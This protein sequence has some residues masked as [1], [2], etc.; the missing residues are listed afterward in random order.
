M[1]IPVNM[2]LVA[3]TGPVLVR[4]WQHRPSTG[5]VLAHSGMFMGYLKVDAPVTTEVKVEPG[6]KHTVPTTGGIREDTENSTTRY[7]VVPDMS[8]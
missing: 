5:P 7:I 4:C 2:P 1:R 3:S 8:L 6:Q